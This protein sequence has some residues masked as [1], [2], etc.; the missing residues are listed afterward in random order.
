MMHGHPE[1]RH[2]LAMRLVPRHSSTSLRRHHHLL[3]F[4]PRPRYHLD[5]DL[6]LP[7]RN[8]SRLTHNSFHNGQARTTISSNS[9]SR[10]HS[11]PN[12]SLSLHRSRPHS[13]RVCSKPP[14][15]LAHSSN[16]RPLR[17]RLDRLTSLRP[18]LCSNKLL[19]FSRNNSSSNNSLLYHRGPRV[20]SVCRRLV[21]S[22]HNSS[23]S[24]SRR[25]TMVLQTHSS[26]K[27]N[28]LNSLCLVRQCKPP[29]RLGCKPP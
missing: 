22:S 10:P 25:R 17:C 13:R 24:C 7:H 6:V 19:A 1:L 4:N 27:L 15:H 16:S 29:C 3:Q 5:R 28:R 26:L 8:R 18:S 2:P 11:R 14:C 9:N 12:L 23:N 20:S 21:S